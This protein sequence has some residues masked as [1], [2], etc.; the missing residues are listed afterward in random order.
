MRHRQEHNWENSQFSRVV[1]RDSNGFF[2]RRHE[3]AA[4]LVLVGLVGLLDYASGYELR[5]GIFYFAPIAFATWRV[6]RAA[7]LFLAG[8]AGFIWLASFYGEHP[9]RHDVFYFWEGSLAIGT[10][11]LF[12]A[13]L[14]RL[15][16]ALERSDS[17]FMTV[18]EGLDDAVFVVAPGSLEIL[19]ANGRF[20]QVFGATCPAGLEGRAVE[21]AAVELQ[22]KATGRW[23]YVHS[24]PLQW[25]D[26][27]NVM[28][29]VLTDISDEKRGRELVRRH[30]DA[31]HQAE[32]LV[33]LG[34]FASAIA[35]ELNQPLAAIAAYSDA[36]LRLLRSG[37]ASASEIGEAVGK[38]REQAKRAAAI[39]ARLRELLRHSSHER[40]AEDLGEIARSAVRLAEPEA[41]ESGAILDTQLAPAPRVLADRVLI[42]QVLMNL[43][44]NAMDAVREVDAD[45]RRVTLSCR[46]TGDAV[47]VSVSDLGK[48][49]PAEQRATLFEPFHTTKPGGLGLGL[50]I[51]HSIIDAH[52]GRLSY[53]PSAAG[54]SRFAFTLPCG[55]A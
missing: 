36:C 24:R 3:L 50:S 21:P 52:G 9:Y 42:E 20:R 54:G 19:F 48:G 32:R 26:G 55:P 18:L 38:C 22:E 10:Y 15:K 35:H 13:L 37:A 4:S 40:K 27:R 7:G 12:V 29:R 34:E 33:A 45:R 44:R 11:M 41:A 47:E 23:Y 46:T 49:V 30:R 28:L 31:A 53:A 39:I 16:E 5:L 25:V 2:A 51:C 1:L 14:A 17:R 6:G 8:V 43:L